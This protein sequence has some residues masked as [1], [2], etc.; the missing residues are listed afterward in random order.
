MYGNDQTELGW[1]VSRDTRRVFALELSRINH[2][3]GVE[4]ALRVM[5]DIDR[6]EMLFGIKDGVLGASLKVVLVER[7]DV[8]DLAEL[9]TDRPKQ[10]TAIEE[11][12]IK[13]RGFPWEIK[14][15]RR[16]DK[17]PTGA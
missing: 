15:V 11:G 17:P 1:P 8:R 12:D 9:R 13:F 3:P 4:T 16:L 2:S 5:E 14:D 10:R 7:V 6:I